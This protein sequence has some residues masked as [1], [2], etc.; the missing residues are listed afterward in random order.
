MEILIAICFTG[1]GLIGGMFFIWKTQRR[2]TTV[3]QPAP[4]KSK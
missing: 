4:S 2:E 3:S 1:I